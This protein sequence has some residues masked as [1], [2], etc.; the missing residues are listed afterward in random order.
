MQGEITIDY[1]AEVDDNDEAVYRQ[2]DVSPLQ[3][4]SVQYPNFVVMSTERC[5]CS[6]FWTY[7]NTSTTYLRG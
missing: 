6:L 7:Q 4:I 3:V 5:V 1:E 2:G